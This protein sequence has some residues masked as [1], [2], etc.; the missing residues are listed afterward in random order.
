MAAIPE[1]QPPGTRILQQI[2]TTT[3][4]ALLPTLPAVMVGVCKEIHELRDSAGALNSDILLSGPCVARADNAEAS[5]TVMDSLTLKIRVNG[6]TIQTFSMPS[7]AGTLTATQVATA[8]NGAT[9]A[10]V[11]FAAYVYEDASSDKYL[12]LRTTADGATKTIQILGGTA[13]TKFGWGALRTF[14]GVGNYL[15]D[16]YELSQDAFPDP[17][18][19]GTE[20]DIIEDQV[21]MFLDLGGASPPEMLRTQAFN[22]RDSYASTPN[23]GVAAVDDVDGDLTTPFVLLKDSAGSAEN[24]IG[25]ATPAVVT[26]IVDIESAPIYLHGQTLTL[27]VDGERPQTVA[28]Y[29]QPVLSTVSTGWTFPTIQSGTMVIQV[30][31]TDVTVTF[32]G[33]VA[34]IDDVVDEINTAVAAAVGIN[35]A[36]RCD[37]YGK[38]DV[39]G[40]Y[41]GLFYG[42]DP[43]A[44]VYDT[45]VKVEAQANAGAGD[46]MEGAATVTADHTQDLQGTNAH[47]NVPVDS[48]TE[49]INNLFSSTVATTAGNFLILTSPGKGRESKIEISDTSSAVGAPQPTPTTYLGLNVGLGG[50]NYYGNP[51]SVRPGDSVYGDGVW[52][53]DVLDVQPGAVVGKLRLNNEVS[54]TG[55]WTSWYIISKTLDAYDPTTEWGVVVPTPDMWIDANN[56]VHVKHDFVRDTAGAP[57]TTVNAPSYLMFDAL[58]KDVTATATNKGLLT[59]SDETTL[60]SEIGP[61]NTDNPVAYA[62][63]L[64]MQTAPTVNIYGLGVDEIA[65]AKPN[66]TIEGF[67][68]A[69]GYLESQEVYAIGILT[70]DDDINSIVKTHVL[71]MSDPDQGSPRVGIVHTDRPTRGNSTLIASGN[72]ADSD[73]TAG[74][75]Y[76]IDTKIPTLSADLLAAGIDPTSIDVSDGLYIDVASSEKHWNIT[77]SVSGGSLLTVNTIFVGDQNV[78]GFY[79]TSTDV[80]DVDGLVSES[81]SVYMRGAAVSDLDD[82]VTALYGKGVALSSRRM[83][84]QFADALQATIGGIE[85]SID[86]FYANAVKA[87]FVTGLKPGT[88]MSKRP[89]PVFTKVT[90]TKDTFKNSQLNQIAAGG[91]DILVQVGSGVQSRHQLT[92][93]P[94]TAQKAEQSITVALD[95]VELYLKK[96]LGPY[97]GRFNLTDTVLAGLSTVFEGLCE[98]LVNQFKVVKFARPTALTQATSDPRKM[99]ASVRVTPFYPGNTFEITIIV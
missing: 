44:I 6:G 45:E 18:S 95:F 86:G 91:V 87:G 31:G 60:A 71:A 75:P 29:G 33:T 99:Q 42:A 8:I 70:S 41:L 80:S 93:D 52:L 73:A 20:R 98:V 69:L 65:T 68:T 10:P 37:Q 54:K 62:M 26:G 2:E 59:Y 89:M 43:T 72:D 3:T 47:A 12:E 83:W 61:I 49:Q 56:D 97:S 5:Y 32:S 14:Y 23:F 28:F 64:G 35:V 58:R 22:R 15:Q 13:L 76:I 4:V 63:W 9:P 92:T 34:D 39:A 51:F 77:G 78:D 66:G 17:H 55:T 11:D 16:A 36:Y 19:I 90:G 40:T 74:T 81:F 94:A 1:L 48:I 85:Q 82:E 96:N 53:G 21:R 88:P 57:V 27:Q 38:A 7:G 79:G 24:L 67:A 46:I 30:N 25:A 84:L 50:Y